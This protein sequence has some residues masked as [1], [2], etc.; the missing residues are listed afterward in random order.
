MINGMYNIID[1]EGIHVALVLCTIPGCDKE[2]G[3]C[4]EGAT[5]AEAMK[6]LEEEMIKWSGYCPSDT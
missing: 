4:G 1:D 5:E 6:K 2:H 3:F